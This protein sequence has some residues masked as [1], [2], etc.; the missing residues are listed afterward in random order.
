MPRYEPDQAAG[1]KSGTDGHRGL[2]RTPERNVFH[3]TSPTP[4]A[5]I[6]LYSDKAMSDRYEF[7][8]LD[9]SRDLRLLYCRELNAVRMDVNL[10]VDSRERVDDFFAQLLGLMEKHFSARKVHFITNAEGLEI[11]DA[12]LAYYAE[13]LKPAFQRYGLALVRFAR[14]LQKARLSIA[15]SLGGVPVAQVETEAEALAIVKDLCAREKILSIMQ[16]AVSPEVAEYM[17]TGDIEPG[18]EE[19]VCTVLFADIRDFTSIAEQ[20]SPK[21]LVDLVNTYLQ[22]MSRVIERHSGVIDKFIGDAI[23]AVWGAP[24]EH[25]SES[26]VPLDADLACE[27]AIDMMLALAEFNIVRTAQAR[28]ALRIGI[29]ID[30]GPVVAG[31]MGSLSRLNYTV[32]GD[33]VNIASRLE[34]ATRSYSVPIIIS[35]FT[36]QA[37][38]TPDRFVSR[39][40]DLLR[41]K[42]RSRPIRVFE[43][44]GRR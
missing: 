36:L 4:G 27:A 43:L 16:K 7:V 10:V 12:V 39:E 28:P 20:L 19:K 25:R 1:K 34:A 11:N 44:V 35:E 17:L 23:M 33:H 37:L 38:T 42:G 22:S 3:L 8:P 13:H 29:G 41:V 15:A 14:G 2:P 26:G 5:E 21:E 40:L 31:I 18:G 24:A 9:S 6:V 32:M 30:T